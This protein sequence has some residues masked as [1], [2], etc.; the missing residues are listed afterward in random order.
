MHLEEYLALVQLLK[1]DVE[2]IDPTAPLMP[3]HRAVA[4]AFATA[5][6]ATYVAH[7]ATPPEL[8]AARAAAA[9]RE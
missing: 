3:Q 2:A 8:S 1:R 7:G 5:A 9:G 6:R 4:R